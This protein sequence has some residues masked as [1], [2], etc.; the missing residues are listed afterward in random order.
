LILIKVENA[1]LAQG[2]KGFG[3]F[4]GFVIGEEA[5]RD[6]VGHGVNM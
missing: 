3:D 6:V 5:D 4:G 1:L 2:G